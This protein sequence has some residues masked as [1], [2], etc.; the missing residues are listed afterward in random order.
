MGVEFRVFGL[1]AGLVR[2]SSAG[3]AI[4]VLASVTFAQS[5]TGTLIGSIR[6][7]QQKV[8]S[9]IEVR[10]SR[11][12]ARQPVFHTTTESTGRFELM[13]LPPGVY[14]LELT[15]PGEQRQLYSHLRIDAARTLEINI[16]LKPQPAQS[17]SVELFDR[18]V[19]VSSYFGPARMR[20]LPSSRRVWSL[21]ANQEPSAVTDQP[22]T[23]VLET[24]RRTL[25]GERAISWTENQYRLNGFDLTDPYLP[26]RPL[27]DPNFDSL[28]EVS[29][30]TAAKPV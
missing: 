25:F 29:V 12:D 27:I 17:R 13:R 3:V 11:L 5:Q 19:V 20:T 16:T 18:D 24:G 9:G 4:C 23:G 1:R 10:L 28:S 7:P 15:L 8:V 2:I 22:D 26:G 6:D 30:I 14:S 21:L